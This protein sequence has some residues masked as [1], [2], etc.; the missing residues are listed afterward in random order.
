VHIGISFLCTAIRS[1][2]RQQKRLSRREDIE[3]YFNRLGEMV[4]GCAAHFIYNVDEMGH[5]EWADHQEKV[6]DVPVSGQQPYGYVTVLG[7]GKPYRRHWAF[8]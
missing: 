1:H 4:E 3:A 7:T 6:C 2:V 8:L 5:H